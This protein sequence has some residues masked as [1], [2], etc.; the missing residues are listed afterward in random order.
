MVARERL[1]LLLPARI[2]DHRYVSGLG[3]HNPPNPTSTIAHINHSGFL[4][5]PI[6][7]PLITTSIT[8]NTT[9][10]AAVVVVIAVIPLRV[11]TTIQA[12]QLV[13]HVVIATV[14]V[15][16]VPIVPVGTTRSSWGTE[17]ILVL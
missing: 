2:T 12:V 11:A 16:V 8:H 17:R 3:S 7:A 4:L 14:L 10:V 15:R 5:A 6:A 1:R 13:T 9:L